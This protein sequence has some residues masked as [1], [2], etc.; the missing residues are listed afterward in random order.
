MKHNVICPDVVNRYFEAMKTARNPK[1][2][3]M[4]ERSTY[5]CHYGLTTYWATSVKK[6]VMVI[7][8]L[9][10][11]GGGFTLRVGSLG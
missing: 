1:A 2:D 10:G 6:R 7:W 8:L 4:L 11:G 5:V 3:H 9:Y